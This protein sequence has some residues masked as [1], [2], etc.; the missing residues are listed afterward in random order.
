MQPEELEYFEKA[1]ALERNPKFLVF[2]A[3]ANQEMAMTM[4]SKKS[5]VHSQDP[6]RMIENAAKLYR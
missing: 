4:F 2:L 1:V 6:D 5:G 3:Q